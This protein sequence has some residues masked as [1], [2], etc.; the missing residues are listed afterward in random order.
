LGLCGDDFHARRETELAEQLLAIFPSEAEGAHICHAETGDD[1]R[2]CRGIA[3]GKLAIHHGVLSPIHQLRQRNLVV[4]I[5]GNLVGNDLFR[6]RHVCILYFLMA[7][8]HGDFSCVSTRL[9]ASS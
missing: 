6:D 1:G 5:R 2:N 9:P 8:I 7:F 3:F 4:K